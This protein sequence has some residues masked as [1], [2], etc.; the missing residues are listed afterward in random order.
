MNKC[1]Y[2]KTKT[3]WNPFYSKCLK[4]KIYWVEWGLP[5][6]LGSILA[7]MLFY[8]YITGGFV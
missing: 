8:T 1:P 3:K 2:C 7:I 6:T 4:C 5:F